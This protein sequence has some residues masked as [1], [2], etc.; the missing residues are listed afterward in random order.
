[1][2]LKDR[3]YT[4]TTTE[5]NRHYESFTREEEDELYLHIMARPSLKMKEEEEKK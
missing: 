3:H 1:M 4:A 2:S 5:I